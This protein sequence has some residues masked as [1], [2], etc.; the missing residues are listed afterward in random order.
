MICPANTI[1][2]IHSEIRTHNTIRTD[3]PSHPGR[4]HRYRVVR[5][6]EVSGLARLP[7]FAPRA[8]ICDLT[9]L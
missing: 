7:R 5:L 2:D 8:A 6:L 1:T 3:T 9:A 4:P